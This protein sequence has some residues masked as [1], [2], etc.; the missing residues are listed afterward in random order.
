MPDNILNGVTKNDLLKLKNSKAVPITAHSHEVVVP[1]VYATRV[2]Q[3]MKRE[4]MRV[5]LE[6][7]EL[8]ALKKKARDTEGT[9]DASMAVG[10]TIKPKKKKSKKE[11]KKGTVIKKGN[12]KQVV[13]IKLGSRVIR[14]PSTRAKVL[15][16]E[17]IPIRPGVSSYPMTTEPAYSRMIPSTGAFTQPTKPQSLMIEDKLPLSSAIVKPS[18][19][20]PVMR[21]P[22]IPPPPSTAPPAPPRVEIRGPLKRP[23]VYGYSRGPAEE[24]AKMMKEDII[25][26]QKAKK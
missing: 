14:T 7:E 12:I 6:P 5:P 20:P 22:S 16:K 3:F 4:G 15:G 23:Q 19:I 13:N 11:V 24:T 25:M 10:G 17:N 8:S 2:K 9:M 1:V 21:P 18:V 26:A